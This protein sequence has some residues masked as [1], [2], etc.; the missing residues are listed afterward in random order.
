[1]KCKV[2]TVE[3]A[4]GA[5]LCPLMPALRSFASCSPPDPGSAEPL[6]PQH[7]GCQA[8]DR[9]ADGGRDRYRRLL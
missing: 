4:T 6:R 1:M 2:D 9:A 8:S 3:G 7:P 5:P